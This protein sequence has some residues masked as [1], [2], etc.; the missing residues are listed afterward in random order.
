MSGTMKT[1]GF[2]LFPAT[3]CSFSFKESVK[4]S[5][6]CSVGIVPM[7]LK[8][9]NRGTMNMEYTETFLISLSFTLR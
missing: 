8:Q 5:M 6:D 9:R 4:E 1:A 2:I 7:T 3:L